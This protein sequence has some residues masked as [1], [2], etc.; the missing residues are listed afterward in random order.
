MGSSWLILHHE[1]IEKVDFA[2]IKFYLSDI[3]GSSI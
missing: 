2:N 1:S 3:I